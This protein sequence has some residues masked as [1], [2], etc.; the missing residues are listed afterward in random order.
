M[1]TTSQ[2]I[3]F[4]VLKKGRPFTYN[5]SA[6]EICYYIECKNEDKF[7]YDDVM[8]IFNDFYKKY[9]LSELGLSE[10]SYCTQDLEI[11]DW[12]EYDCEVCIYCTRVWFLRE[13]RK[14]FICLKII[15]FSLAKTDRKFILGWDL[16]FVAFSVFTKQPL[17]ILVEIDD[18]N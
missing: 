5:V 8:K 17:D 16:T 18:L 4:N 9:K 10:F 15:A 12:T 11:C 13:K 6:D 14:R 3:F 7:H 1:N 2:M